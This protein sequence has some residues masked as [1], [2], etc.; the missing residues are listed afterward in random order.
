MQNVIHELEPQGLM[1]CCAEGMVRV[2]RV[3]YSKS[4]GPRMLHTRIRLGG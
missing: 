1:A 2:L 3:Y 4:L